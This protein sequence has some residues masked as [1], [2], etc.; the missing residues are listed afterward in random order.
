MLDDGGAYHRRCL[1]IGPLC[2]LC[3]KA[4]A[5]GSHT[6]RIGPTQLHARCGEMLSWS[7]AAT[8]P[9]GPVAAPVVP[10]EP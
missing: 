2:A 9:I 3:A 6:L 8:S 5:P 4:I 10:V 1:E 7:A